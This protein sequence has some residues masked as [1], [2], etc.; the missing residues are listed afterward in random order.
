MGEK[1]IPSLATVTTRTFL[2]LW[3]YL[4]RTHKANWIRGKLWQQQ[5]MKY[6]N[7]EMNRG[8]ERKRISAT[9]TL[10][11][12]DPLF[13]HSNRVIT[14]AMHLSKNASQPPG[15]K[16]SGTFVP[17]NLFLLDEPGHMSHSVKEVT[18]WKGAV[19]NRPRARGGTLS[20]AMET[21]PKFCQIWQ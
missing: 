20:T 2:L 10:S 1:N 12:L 16:I 4:N 17:T 13:F 11:G 14:T 8:V 5:K 7:Q 18:S 21:Q 3:P 9:Q 6:S 19:W 15:N